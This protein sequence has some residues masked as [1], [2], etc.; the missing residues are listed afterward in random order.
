[1]STSLDWGKEGSTHI[2]KLIFCLEK[3]RKEYINNRIFT[4]YIISSVIE[5]VMHVQ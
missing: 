4:Y 2:S 5:I 1:M 3:G